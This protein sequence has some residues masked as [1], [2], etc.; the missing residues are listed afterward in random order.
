MHRRT[1]L[2]TKLKIKTIKY[3]LRFPFYGCVIVISI[4]LYWSFLVCWKTNRILSRFSILF[5]INPFV[6][7]LVHWFHSIM[8]S[9]WDKY[10]I[11]VYAGVTVLN[12]DQASSSKVSYIKVSI[13][14]IAWRVVKVAWDWL[15]FR[16]EFDPSLR[17]VIR[18]WHDITD[19]PQTNEEQGQR[20]MGK[21]MWMM[22]VW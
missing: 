11:K 4:R 9:G 15:S 21:M 10:H 1:L 20:R 6:R 14:W 5:F 13:N 16:F 7:S 12:C 8:H 3:N 17:A 22:L 19:R 18:I 2:H